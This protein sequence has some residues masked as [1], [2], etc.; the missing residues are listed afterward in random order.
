MGKGCSGSAIAPWEFCLA[1]WDAQFLGDPA[2]R[3]SEKEKENLRWEAE[4][5]RAG[6][7]WHRWDYPNR[8]SGP[9]DERYPVMAMYLA[10]NWRAFRTWGMSAISPWEFGNYWELRKGVEPGTPGAEG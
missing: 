9:F 1:E 6:E 5:F 3:I 10:D 4:K 8:L 2:Y 7:T